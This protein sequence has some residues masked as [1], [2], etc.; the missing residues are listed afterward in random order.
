MKAKFFRGLAYRL[1]KELVYWTSIRLLSHA[2]QGKWAEQIVP[3]LLA[4]DALQR[5]ENE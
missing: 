4:M 1:P 2:T 3:D 5:W